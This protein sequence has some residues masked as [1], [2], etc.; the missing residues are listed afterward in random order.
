MMYDTATGIHENYSNM[1]CTPVSYVQTKKRS[2]DST[3]Q[4]VLF[5]L[6]ENMLLARRP[7]KFYFVSGLIF[8]IFGLHERNHDVTF[9]SGIPEGHKMQEKLRIQL[10][11]CFILVFELRLLQNIMVCK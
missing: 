9:I 3:L 1:P 4:H 6:A 8:D 7:G 10:V 5:D 11:Q 2:R